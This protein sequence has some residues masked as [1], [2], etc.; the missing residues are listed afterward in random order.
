MLHRKRLAISNDIFL[1][2]DRDSFKSS[3]SNQST[4]RSR[5]AHQHHPALAEIRETEAVSHVH[6]VVVKKT[7]RP[8]PTSMLPLLYCTS[9]LLLKGAAATQS[10]SGFGRHRF[11]AHAALAVGLAAG[12]G[13]L[14]V[15]VAQSPCCS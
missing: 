11:S 15:A 13:A 4:S 14:S 9:A 2:F 10:S 6:T 1:F 3:I 12:G 5:A 7:Q 8:A